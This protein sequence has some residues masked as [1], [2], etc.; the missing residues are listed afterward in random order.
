MS[1]RK[2]GMAAVGIVCLAVG[3]RWA[4]G[5]WDRYVPRTLL[6]VIEANSSLVSPDAARAFSADDFPTRAAVIFRGQ[7]RPIPESRLAFMREYFGTFRHLPEQVRLFS[8]EVLCREGDTEYWLP[9]QSSVLTYFKRQVARGD[10]VD[11]FATWLGARRDGDRLDWVFTVNEF[12]VVA[13]RDR[14]AER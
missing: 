14:P 9:I 7:I 4:A 5:G 12:Q 1:H 10:S 3:V 8:H 11:V 13:G 6:S 2:L